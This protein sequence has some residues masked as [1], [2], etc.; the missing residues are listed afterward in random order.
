[1]LHYC[2]HLSLIISQSFD[3]MFQRTKSSR[4]NFVN[5]PIRTKI[6]QAFLR[7]IIYCLLIFVL[8]LRYFS[9]K[10]VKQTH[11]KNPQNTETNAK[12]YCMRLLLYYGNLMVRVAKYFALCVV[13]I[14][15][16]LTLSP[17][18]CF[19]L[20]YSIFD[21]F[22]HFV[23]WLKICDNAQYDNILFLY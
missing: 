9:T 3:L 2:S 12:I 10:Y 20:Y 6:W 21:T 19:P 15:P 4:V 5:R 18:F 16:F 17:F 7:Y 22:K 1:L 11:T 8:L 14:G 23:E 13:F